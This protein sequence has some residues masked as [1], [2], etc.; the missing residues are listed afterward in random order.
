MGPFSISVELPQDREGFLVV[1][2]CGPNNLTPRKGIFFF[3]FKFLSIDIRSYWVEF[4]K[5][6]C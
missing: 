6:V 2:V 4:L 1:S 5:T 3:F